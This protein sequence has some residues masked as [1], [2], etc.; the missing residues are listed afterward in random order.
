[1]EQRELPRREY[2]TY[3]E[4]FYLVVG[5]E[6]YWNREIRQEVKIKHILIY[7]VV[8]DES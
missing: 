1:M 3:T 4:Y 8:R 7:F 2:K 5:E 6:L